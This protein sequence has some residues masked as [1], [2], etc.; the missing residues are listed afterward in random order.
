M[1]DDTRVTCYAC[2]HR[3]RGQGGMMACMQP[4]RAGLPCAPKATYVEIGRDLATLPQHCPAYAALKCSRCG[5][6]H[7][8]SGCPWP[9]GGQAK[10]GGH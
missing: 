5:G 3:Q 10:K 6:A 2:T 7:S 9:T 4:K 1:T 8:V